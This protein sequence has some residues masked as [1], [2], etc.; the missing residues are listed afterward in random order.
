M[1]HK[2][3][4]SL[5][6]DTK[7]LFRNMTLL[8]SVLLPVL[9]AVMFYF[10]LESIEN[11]AVG[12]HIKNR[13]LLILFYLVYGI[14]LMSALT[15]NITTSMAEENEKGYFQHFVHTEKDYQGTIWSKVILY[16]IVSVLT[17]AVVMIIFNPPL[18][19]GIYDYVGMACIF[20]VFILLGIAIGLTAKSVSQT[21]VFIIP[22]MIFIAMTPMGEVIFGVYNEAAL[23][24]SWFNLLYLNMMINEG[25]VWQRMLGNAVYIVLSFLLVVFCYRHKRF[26]IE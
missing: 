8:T 22:F 24:V 9:L 5:Y 26:K 18:N 23:S 14:T 6:R 4:A 3:K 25:Q 16:S 21:A 13:M 19:F 15:F 1:W 2:I 7:E 17:V 20:V 10:T 12:A 11:E